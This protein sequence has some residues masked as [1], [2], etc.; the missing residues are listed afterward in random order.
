MVRLAATSDAPAVLACVSAAFE[1]YIDRIGKPP[2]PMLLDYPKLIAERSVWVVERVAEIEGVLVQFETTDGFYIDTVAS[3]PRARGTGVG[4]ALLQ[5]AEREATR[6][7]YASVCLCTNSKMTE[8]QVFY[9][10]IGYVEY[11][12]KSEAG[13][14]R[15][16]YRKSLA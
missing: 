10:R 14:D 3:R 6:R 16:F 12:R 13:Y 8:N 5:F 4:R 2:A 9:P 1:M 15:V 7:G 11:E